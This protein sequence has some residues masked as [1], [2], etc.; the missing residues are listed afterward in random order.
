MAGAIEE[1]GARLVLTGGPK[2]AADADAFAASIDKITAAAT[3]AAGAL[4]RMALSRDAVGGAAVEG[5]AGAAADEAAA[6]EAANL[7]KQ[8]ST[9]ETTGVVEEETKKQATAF[10][11]LAS[12]NVVKKVATWGTGALALGAYESVKQYA[13]YNKL[14]T[15]SA[16]DAGINKNQLPQISKSLLQDSRDTGVAAA[17]MAN[18]FYRVQS[19]MSGTHA[20]L[21]QVLSLTKEAAGL[22][23]LFNIA[24]GNATEQT[25]RII[26]AMKNSGLSGAG[27]PQQIEALL[28]SAVGHGDI[29]GQ[30]MIAALGKMLPAAKAMGANAP[31]M[32]AWVDTLT[33]QGMQGSQAGTLIA[34]SVQQLAEPS[35]QGNK[36]EQM[37][38]INGGD[39]KNMM[40]SKGIPATIEYLQNAMKKFNPT[41][42]YPSFSGNSPGGAS[43]LA[44]LQAWGIADPATLAAFQSGTMDKT[45][46]AQIQQA[47][48]SKIFGGAKGALPMLALMN[49]PQAYQELDKSIRDAATP[50]ALKVA[51]ANAMNTP[52]R[53]MDIARA[54]IADTGIQIGKEIT[55]AVTEGLRI[56]GQIAKQLSEHPGALMGILGAITAVT[57]S[58]VTISAV[59]KLQKLAQ[60]IAGIGKALG[61]AGSWAL[62]IDKEASA[63]AAGAAPE[64]AMQGAASTM[65]GAAN[66]ML[67]AARSMSGAAGEEVAAGAAQDAAGTEEEAGAIAGLGGKKGL[68][69]LLP[70]LAGS[71]LA[72]ALAPL[73][74]AAG[75]TGLA[76]LG[77]KHLPGDQ[78]ILD[79]WTGQHP[80]INGKLFVTPAQAAAALHGLPSTRGEATNVV[81]SS[82]NPYRGS[83]YS[84]YSTGAGIT[85]HYD[86]IHLPTSTVHLSGGL[87][88]SVNRILAEVRS[89]T[90]AGG[91]SKK[92]GDYSLTAPQVASNEAKA[93][94]TAADAAAKQLSQAASLQK[95]AQ[96][97][98]KQASTETGTA[99]KA[100]QAAS[101]EHEAAAKQHAAAA[102]KLAS[103]AESIDAAAAKLGNVQIQATI[104][105]TE[106]AAAGINVQANTV[107]RG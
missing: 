92:L 24:P 58:A 104:S 29:R 95:E 96:T 16:V 44:Q 90:A 87:A 43:A 62:G 97:E 20:S 80:T 13:N 82:T 60:S 17:D 78:S 4:D 93:G 28:Q 85:S 54:N 14:L 2:A 19:A 103:A 10:E 66:T 101:K 56:F 22:D 52:G 45:Q 8:Q 84:S 7:R 74:A 48:I 100:S 59:S 30:D 34:H 65:Q 38:G 67:A 98:A 61:N 39:L 55:P 40:A 41:S 68:S 36:A 70:G 64:E 6:I 33:K 46:Q 77:A 105:A 102:A 86:S 83:Q 37:L 11:A 81:G 50:E 76:L 71:P 94:S 31:D 3:E 27:D 42:Y 88:T 69:K 15:Q 53:Q 51:M 99:A 106:V 47:L 21:K 1:V 23:V 63:V 9:K 49:N 79:T 75:I 57:A 5:S 35:E 26:G 89:S 73:A 18:S 25:A 72:A 12:N 91:Y 107:A 32:L